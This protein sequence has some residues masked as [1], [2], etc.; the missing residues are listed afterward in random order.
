MCTHQPDPKTPPASLLARRVGV[1][2]WTTQAP[3]PPAKPHQT[4]H[5]GMSVCE[6]SMSQP[7]QPSG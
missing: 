6:A 1:T 2:Y 7:G 4:Q 3:R 5:V